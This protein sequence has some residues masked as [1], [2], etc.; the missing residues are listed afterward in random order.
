MSWANGVGK[1]FGKSAVENEWKARRE[2]RQAPMEEQQSSTSMY[3]GMLIFS[4]V[5]I[6]MRPTE[7]L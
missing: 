2:N 6:S 1:S 3:P 4:E 5:K 7:R